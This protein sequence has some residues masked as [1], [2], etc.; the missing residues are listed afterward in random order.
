MK[1][2]R[3]TLVLMILAA[4]LL[5]ACAPVA[6]PS[7]APSEPPPTQTQPPLPEPTATEPLPE[8]TVEQP[9][10]YPADPVTVSFQASDGQELSGTFLPAAVADAPVVVLM[11]Q[12]N[13]NGPYEWEVIADWLQNRGRLKE[14]YNNPKN[15]SF[16]D[17]AWF[18]AMPADMPLA[19]FYFTFRGCDTSRGC[20][21]IDM[22]GW[23]LDA[24]AAVQTAVAQPGI[25]PAKII[26]I[27]TSIG[28]DGAVDGCGL[29]PNMGA[30][31]QPCLG[32]MPVSPGS[33]LELEY[34]AF[35]KMLLQGGTQQ[36]TCVAPEKEATQEDGCLSFEGE[37][38]L[39]EIVPNG[40]HGIYLAN[41]AVSPDLLTIMLTFL[42]DVL[43]EG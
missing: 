16:R 34:P 9:P 5:A 42:G 43:G 33:Y 8:P 29:A 35:A 31:E 37:G 20:T 11:H 28:A 24:V 6:T 19:V 36:I 3:S 39:T 21:D 14:A 41:P 13:M 1:L 15:E 10:A 38:Y 26:T 18:P 32:V 7:A 23:Q 17:P 4:L 12:I 2:V 30:L 22:A 40:E 25:D 27:G